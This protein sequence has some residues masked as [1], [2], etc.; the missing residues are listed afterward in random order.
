LVIWIT[1]LSKAHNGKINLQIDVQIG[2]S[3]IAA[4]Q[5]DYEPM[6]KFTIKPAKLADAIAEH[7]QQII[8]EGVLKPGERLLP[9]RE[10]AIKLDVSRPTLREALEKLISQGLLTANAQGATFVSADIGKSIRDPLAVL[11]DMP[12]AAVDCLELR[13]VVETAA[14]GFAADR[15]SEVDRQVIH[16]RF[17]AM[18]AAHE[19]QNV[20]N[21]AA[22]DAEFHFAIYEATHNVAM[23]HFMRSLESLLRS[24][25]YLNRKNLYERRTQKDSQLRE[26]QAIHDAIM[27]GS[28]ERA[29]EAARLHMMTAIETQREIYEAERRLEVAVRRLSHDDL[30]VKTRN[31][32]K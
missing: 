23:I 7:L 24:N 18:L 17:E 5:S 3:Q 29:R 11:F 9:E 32:A 1:V 19:E 25:I 10:L 22:T 20:D 15:A 6:T 26:H 21:I 16:G 28:P 12:Q 4:A 13:L 27:E 31:K 2:G 14:A 30:V 8:F